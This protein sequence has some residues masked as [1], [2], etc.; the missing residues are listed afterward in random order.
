MKYSSVRRAVP[1]VEPQGEN[2]MDKLVRIRRIRY[3]TLRAWI[4][5]AEALWDA[6]NARLKARNEV[7]A[8]A[9]Q[10]TALNDVK[11]EAVLEAVQIKEPENYGKGDW[12]ARVDKATGTFP[13]CL[14]GRGREEEERCV[15]A[16]LV[17]NTNEVSKVEQLPGIFGDWVAVYVKGYNPNHLHA[18][19]EVWIFPRALLE[20]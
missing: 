15:L 5:E 19:L 9:K 12:A 18:D 13:T 7:L 1:L 4:A 17:H 10:F 11:W 14:L 20:D 16:E 6:Y 8:Y 3:T 2:A